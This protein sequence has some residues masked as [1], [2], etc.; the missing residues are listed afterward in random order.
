MRVSCWRRRLIRNVGWS[1][2]VMH[3]IGIDLEG[4]LGNYNIG[5][6]LQRSHF[7]LFFIFC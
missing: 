2:V 5:R 4:G 6:L 7:I 3:D 1:M